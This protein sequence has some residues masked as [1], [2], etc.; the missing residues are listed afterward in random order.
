MNA[1]T[2]SA[3][4]Q[5]SNLPSAQN[6]QVNNDRSNI[7][8]DQFLQLLMAQLKNQDP[9]NPSNDAS[10]F[11]QQMT[12]FGQ[13]EQLFNLNDSF[14]S[15]NSNQGL[16]QRTQAV[17]MLGKQI[18]SKS[19]LVEVSGSAPPSLGFNLNQ[20]ARSVRVEVVDTLGRT[21]KTINYENQ[22]A[23]SHFYDFDPTDNA[24]HGMSGVYSLRITAQ[25]QDGRAIASQSILRG[26]VTGVDYSSGNPLLKVGSR[27]VKID[28]V[29]SLST[30]G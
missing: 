30:V 26:V 20:P 5:A 27:L 28:D 15:M 12:Q 29:T 14:K 3:L 6:S 11:T 8:K 9:M 13:L 18:E 1:D 19:N 16:M 17:G 22:T 4:T 23:G 21:V 2:L 25:A 7:K 24:G 10:Q